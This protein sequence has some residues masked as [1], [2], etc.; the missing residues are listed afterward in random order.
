M[1][2]DKTYAGDVTP[3]HAWQL[4]STGQALIVDIRSAEEWHFVGHV[5]SSKHV[6]WATGIALSRNPEFLNQLAQTASKDQ[7]LLL[8]CRSSKRSVSAAQAAT[9]AGY[10]QVFNILEGFEGDPN[11]SGQRGGVNGW[12][13][14]GLPWVQS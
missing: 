6:A 8:L 7:T 1:N 13:K 14:R 10:T 4:A 11:S 3:E 5:P 12:Q 9:A 2:E